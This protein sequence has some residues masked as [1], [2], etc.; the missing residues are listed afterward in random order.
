[1]ARVG[2]VFLGLSLLS[3]A[4]FG[5]REGSGQGNSGTWVFSSSPFAELW[6]HGLAMVDPV[7]PGPVP[8]YGAAYPGSVRAAKQESGDPSTSLDSRLGYFR[9]AFRRD[10]AF[11]V[12]HFLPL[13]FPQVGRT[14][15]FAALELLAGA[16]EGIPRAPTARTSFG[17]AAIGSV[18]TTQNQR[19]VLGEF[20]S[21]L[22]AEWDGFFGAWWQGSASD[23]EVLYQEIQQSWREDY[24]AVLTPWLDRAEMDGGLVTFVPAL[25]LEGRIFGGSPQSPLDN[26][27]MISA[28][29]GPGSGEE[30]IFSMLRELSFP[31]VRKVLTRL[32]SQAENPDEEESLA[33]RAAI[34]SGALV[35]ERYSPGNLTD[36]QQFFLSRAGHTAPTLTQVESLFQRAFLMN[37]EL[38]RALR[39]E[40]FTTETHGGI[41]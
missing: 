40:I 20:I 26:V 4:I 19:R 2:V 12:F 14:E 17:V 9:E 34:R 3:C 41:G 7:G 13:Y 27:L 21:A 8:L 35:L 37:A 5:V 30:A 23:R 11:E 31:L 28:P 18:L 29:S 32:G 15:A 1:M 39:E 36:Y 33:S 38:E 10:P 24:Q 22:E 16:E 25:G 6:F